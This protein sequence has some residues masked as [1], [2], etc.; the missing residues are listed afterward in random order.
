MTQEEL[1][2]LMAGDLEEGDLAEAE[3]SDVEESDGASDEESVSEMEAGDQADDYKVT[4]DHQWPPPPPTEEHK[5]VHQLDEVTQDSEVKAGEVFDVLES[6]S[7]DSMEIEEGLGELQEK[8]GETKEVF[9]KLVEQFP[10]IETFKNEL[11]KLETLL[12]S[13]ETCQ[14]HSQNINDSTMVAMDLMQYQDI[15]RQKIERV[16]NVM[17]TLSSYMNSLFA[18]KVDDKKRVSSAK[19]IAGDSTEDVVNEEDIE[20][21]IASFGAP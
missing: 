19:H 8:L 10:N 3:E 17:R 2:A 11:E 1:D 18:G 16:I 6:I 5:V 12:G 4:A 13:I 7:N 15:H 21:L 9:E 20:A 14:G